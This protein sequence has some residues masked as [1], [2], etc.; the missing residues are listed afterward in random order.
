MS[1]AMQTHG[2]FSWCE[3]MTKDIPA[4]VRFYQEVLGWEIEEAPFPDMTYFVIKDS[5]GAMVGGILATPPEAAGT[6]PNW[7]AYV[8]VKDVDAA[9]SAAEKAGGKILLPPRE[10]PMV[11]RMSVIQD[12]QGAV[13]S[14]ITYAS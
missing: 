10:I 13:L 4:A 11:G 14:L 3:L 1:D 5:R 12:P 9:T 8:T 2:A 6:P 7:G